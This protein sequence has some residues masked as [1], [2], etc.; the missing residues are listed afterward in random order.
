MVCAAL[1]GLAAVRGDR[2]D[3]SAVLHSGHG[4]GSAQ[5]RGRTSGLWIA[6]SDWPATGGHPFYQRLNRDLN[7]HAFDDFAEAQCA[8]FYAATRGRP[9]LTPG[10]DFRLPLIG[11]FEGIVSERGIA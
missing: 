7:D 10:T 5:D 9:S 4:H 6:T 8:S 1:A 11:Y 3:R 2:H